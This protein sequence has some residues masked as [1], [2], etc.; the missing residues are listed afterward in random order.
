[1]RNILKWVAIAAGALVVIVGALFA[2]VAA[3]FDPNDYKPTIVKA[4]QEKTGRKLDLKGDIKLSLF[5]TLGVKLGQTSLS[6]HNS[7]AEFASIAE[8][9]AAVKLMPLL[10]KNV[11]VDAV[12]LRGLKVRVEK[13]PSGKFNFD[14]LTR[15]GKKE[16]SDD[17]STPTPV[18]VDIGHVTVADGDVTYIDRGTDA[19]YRISKLNLTTGRIA[20][21]VTTPIDLSAAVAVPK[22]KVTLDLKLKTKL[23]ADTERQVYKLADLAFSTTGDLENLSGLNAS[24]KGNVEARL[25]TSEFVVDG[26]QVDVSGKQAGGDV[27]AK[28]DAPKLTLTKDKVDGGKIALDAATSAPGSRLVLKATVAG[29]QGAFNSFKAGPLDADIEAQGDGRTTKARLTGTLD[30]NLEAR[31]FEMANLALKA[32]VT[33]PKLPKGSLDASIAGTA[34]ADVGKETAALDFNGKLDESNVNGKAGVTR[35]SP[36]ALTFD[37]NADQLDVDRLMGKTPGSKQ[38]GGGSKS[39]KS[40]DEKIDLSGLKNV[41]ATGAVRIAKLTVMNLQSQQVRVDLKVANGRLDVAPVAAQLYQ[42]TLNGTFSAV[43]AQNP[44]FTVKQTLSG[45]ALGPLLRDAA[46]IDTLEGKG[47]ISADLQTRGATV[48]ALKKAL[49]GKA[50]VNL[51][52]GSIKGMDVGAT[53]RSARANLDQLRGRPVQQ[54]NNM[55]QKTDFSELKASFTIRNGVAHNEDLSL[56][57]PLLRVGGAGDIDIGNDRLDY[58]LKATVVATSKGQGGRDASDL[59]GVTVPV[60][61][62]GALDTPQWSIDFG[63]MATGLARHALEKELLKRVPGSQGDGAPAGVQD[64]LKDRLKGLFGR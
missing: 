55:A 13:D 41:N 51:A 59:S 7:D 42:G 20:N 31:R 26:L 49:N 3:T 63:G 8:A 58:V 34:R 54:S 9:L 11:V 45:V 60:K 50:S 38:D 24:A 43:A 6:E 2:Y 48:D 10:S 21:G 37:L 27:K 33:D 52:D 56:K 25:A 18:A 23:T 57:S 53:I 1:M 35:F 64:T 46:R 16:K 61:L 12:E 47:T 17:K 22:Q 40:A 36:L 15:E 62:T 14:D 32:K 19:Q 30:G 39:A 28:L 4:V 5:P 44:V 29:V